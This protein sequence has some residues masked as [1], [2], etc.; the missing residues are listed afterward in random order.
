MIKQ[1]YIFLLF[2]FFNIGV[3]VT[4]TGPRLWDTAAQS[5]TLAETIES[6]VDHLVGNANNSD[7]QGTFTVIDSLIN[8]SLTLQSYLDELA[9]SYTVFQH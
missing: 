8:K 9:S 4:S 7:I 2:L 5:E 6:Q 3:V 1:I